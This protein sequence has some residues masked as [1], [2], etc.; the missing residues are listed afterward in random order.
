MCALC[1]ALPNNVQFEVKCQHK[2]LTPTDICS[3][4][5]SVIARV[6]VFV[7]V[8][9]SKALRIKYGLLVD[10]AVALNVLDTPFTTNRFN[11]N[12]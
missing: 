4:S 7:V 5:M 9:V 11:S 3:I 10:G 8:L 6:I 1:K 2:L 12:S